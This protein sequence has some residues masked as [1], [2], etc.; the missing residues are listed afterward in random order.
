M[1][2]K[3]IGSVRGFCWSMEIATELDS[4]GFRCLN[5][6]HGP[7]RVWSFRRHQTSDTHII[8]KAEKR[9]KGKRKKSP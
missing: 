5:A 1:S 3:T 8:F 4:T 7:T 6:L 9:Q 2:F